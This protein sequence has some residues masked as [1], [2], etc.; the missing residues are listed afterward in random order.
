MANKTKKFINFGDG[1]VC[2]E[3]ITIC[4]II[5]IIENN[6]LLGHPR[7]PCCQQWWLGKVS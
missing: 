6:Q 2:P 5:G 4:I 3:L 1:L 7:G